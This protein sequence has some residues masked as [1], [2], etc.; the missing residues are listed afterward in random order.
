[1]TLL[2]LD[3]CDKGH[4]HDDEVTTAVHNAIRHGDN[5]Q[6]GQTGAVRK[7]CPAFSS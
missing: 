2:C 3:P 4:L 6:R 5:L 7:V 1:M